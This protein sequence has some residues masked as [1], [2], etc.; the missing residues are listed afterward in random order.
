M[1]NVFIT[2]AAGFIGSS[3]A[4]GLP[5]HGRRVAGRDDFSAGPGIIRALS[6]LRQNQRV[7]KH[8]SAL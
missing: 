5:A 6:W 3:L 1:Q 4:D 2:G 8:R 7:L